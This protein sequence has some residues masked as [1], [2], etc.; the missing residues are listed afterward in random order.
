[1]DVIHLEPRMKSKTFLCGYCITATCPL[2]ISLF[3]TW[4]VPPDWRR[5]SLFYQ[6]Y[7]SVQMITT[8]RYASAFNEF[9]KS[10]KGLLRAHFDQKGTRNTKRTSQ[11]SFD[12]L[13][14]ARERPALG[15]DKILRFLANRSITYSI[16]LIQISG[17][18]E[19]SFWGVIV[20]NSFS[21]SNSS[22]HHR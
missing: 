18:W 2:I 16:P 14:A 11:N 1:M 3:W 19:I 15:K 20:E 7:P 9:K 10:G 17:S 5:L 4:S 21:S 22:A 6:S 8:C 12:F 13:S